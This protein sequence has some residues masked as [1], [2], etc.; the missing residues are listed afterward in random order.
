M[1]EISL[2]C[3]T[4]DLTVADQYLDRVEAVG[5]SLLR[6]VLERD[7]QG[8]L[9]VGRIRS[10]LDRLIPSLERRSIRLAI[11][12]HF[13]IP[14]KTL[15]RAVLGYP[16]ERIGFCVDIANSLRNF[17]DTESVLELLSER[18]F[19]YHLKDYRVYGSNVGFSVSGAP[20]GDGQVSLHSVLKHIFGRSKSPEIYLETWTPSTG[21]R[22]ADIIADARWLERSIA[23]LRTS[24]AITLGTN[25]IET[26]SHSS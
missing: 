17:E 23:N 4:V 19:C 7:G 21:D 25:G 20:L 16:A 9:G 24:L 18:A 8:D 5:G 14:S 11:E 6:I 3:M 12:N 26:E 22:Q 1:L 15:V 10:F 2:G 13:A